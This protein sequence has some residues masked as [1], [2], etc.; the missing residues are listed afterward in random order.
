MF[1]WQEVKVYVTIQSG[2]KFVESEGEGNWDHITPDAIKQA[3]GVLSRFL[4]LV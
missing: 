1:F 2:L 4:S 3:I